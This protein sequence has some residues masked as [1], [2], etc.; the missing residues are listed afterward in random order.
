MTLSKEQKQFIIDNFNIF[1]KKQINEIS[2]AEYN[3]GK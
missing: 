1:E 3:L 2:K